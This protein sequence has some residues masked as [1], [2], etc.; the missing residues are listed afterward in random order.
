MTGPMAIN[1]EATILIVDDEQYIR[2]LL[3][4]Q[5]VGSGY[6]VLLAECGNEAIQI[7]ETKKDEIGLVLLDAV[8]PNA[9]GRN[10]IPDLKKMNPLV[11][12]I[13]MSG[14]SKEEIPGDIACQEVNGF[15]QKPFKMDML[16]KMI[17]DTLTGK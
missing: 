1:C 17:C 4:D 2:D 9:T 11:K 14:Y 12:I 7:Y 5:L 3:L 8:M 10:I 6:Q 16:T 13:L 15:V